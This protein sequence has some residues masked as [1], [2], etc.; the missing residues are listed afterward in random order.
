MK[1]KPTIL[2]TCLFLAA[3]IIL[4][5]S[6]GDD[7]K[8]INTGKKPGI[9]TVKFEYGPSLDN[10]LSS[11]N[12][13][14]ENAT[15]PPAGWIKI[16]VA[17]GSTGWNRQLVGTT[18]VPGFNGGVITSPPGGGNAVAFCNYETGGSSSND[19]WLVT[20]QLTNIQ[21]VDSLRFW[22]RKFGAYLD[23]MDIKISTTTPTVAAMTTTVALLSF[24]ATDSGWIYYQYNIGSMVTPGSNIYIGFRQWVLNALN[25]GASFSLDLVSVTG[26]VGVSNNNNEIPDAYSLSQNYPNPFNPSTVIGYSIPEAGYVKLAVYD[27]LGREMAVPVNEFKPAGKYNVTFDASGLSSGV[28]FYRLSS[29]TFTETK[30][31]TLLR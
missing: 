28:Y 7:I 3:S 17:Q 30:R 26:P 29:G 20:P 1:L 16:N 15:F 12:E 14:F 2:I 13:S 18:P 23:H 5:L 24:S 19:Q 10:P 9:Q 4:G 22:L 6:P 31:M 27:A 21:P 25:D 11:L 8:S